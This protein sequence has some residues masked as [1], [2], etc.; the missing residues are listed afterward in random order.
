MTPVTFKHLTLGSG[1]PKICVPITGTDVTKVIGQAGEV[2]SSST[3]LVEWRLDYLN[4][5]EDLDQLVKTAN[6][7][8]EI[9]GELPLIATLRDRTEGGKRQIADTDYRDIYTQLLTKTKI[10]AI[11]LEWQ[12]DPDTIKNL[13]ALADSNHVRTII[14][15][16]EF[17]HTPAETDMVNQLTAMARTHGSVV[18]L[19]V[20]PKTSDDVLALMNATH[21]VSAAIDQPLITMAMGAL[22]A[23]TRI[24][25]QTFNSC[26]T[27]ASVHSQSAPGQL[28]VE[29]TRQILTTLA[30][31][32]EGLET[33]ALT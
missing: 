27:F 8:T 21:Q 2:V 17:D 15:H 20:M 12:R 4:N 29:Q 33:S 28:S 22:G 10:T 19:A 31:N 26:L 5:L 32:I 1:L 11:D 24:A 16:H 23:V 3:D 13:I 18:K 30:P 14:S 7:L 25:G 6:R 9:L